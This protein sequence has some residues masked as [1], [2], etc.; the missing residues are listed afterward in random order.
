[1]AAYVAGGGALLG[2]TLGIVGTLA[3]VRV[4]ARAA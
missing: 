2:V 1:M 3:A 4:Q